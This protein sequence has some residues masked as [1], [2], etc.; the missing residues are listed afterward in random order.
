VENIGMDKAES[1]IISR[2]SVRIMLVDDHPNTAVTLGRA[3][4]RLRE[5]IEVITATSGQEALAFAEQDAIDILITDMM[6]PGMNGFELIEHLHAHPAGR[7]IHTMLMTAYDVP[8]L[9]ETARRLR[10]HDIIIKPV[11]TE[12]I[13]RI[14]AQVL[15]NIGRT[16]SQIQ[17]V[18]N[19]HRFKILIADDAPDNVTL[20]SRYMT[21]EG[22]DYITASNGVEALE[23]ARLEVP[24][25]ILLDVNM[26]EKDG[27]TALRELRAD[28]EIRHIPVIIL[29]A[30]RP[31]PMDIQWGLNLGA[32]DYITKPFDKRE[33][34]ARIRTKLRVKET[35]DVIR[36]R[37]RELSVLPEIGKELSAR[38]DINELTHV[39]LHRTVETLG[40]MMGHIILLDPKGPVHKKYYISEPDPASR[41]VRFPPL[42]DLVDQIKNTRQGLIID[43]TRTDPRWQLIPEN[44]SL[45]MTIV[46]MFGRLDLIGLL[47]L[48][49]EKKGYFKLEH[50]LLLQAIASQA[51]IAVEN[52]QLYE[53]MAQEQSRLSAVLQ[54]AA[55]AIMMFGADGC[56]SLL[57][58]SA[59]T[60]F[61]DYETKLGLPL[62]RN[63]GYDQLIAAL[64]DVLITGKSKTEEILWPD[65]RI[66]SVSFTHVERGGCVVLLHDV[67]HF[68]VLERVKDE[69]IATA[70]HD[71]RNPITAINGFS[72][73][74]PAVGP[75]NEQ[76]QYFAERIHFAAENMKE[77]VENMLDIARIDAGIELQREPLDMNN[78]V[79]EIA[80]EFEPQAKAKQQTLNLNTSECV[81]E[82][83]GD[84]FQLKQALRNLVGNAIKYTPVNGIVDLFTE[85]EHYNV[86]VYVR[87]NGYGI[88]AE[89]LPHIFDRFY[90]VREGALSDIQGN[91]LGLAI[92]KSIIERHGGQI[93]VESEWGKGS[94]LTVTLPLLQQNESQNE[95]IGIFEL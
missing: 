52:A 18:E 80:Q 16:N 47:I 10:I 56:L 79:M 11:P 67:S 20:L 13:C 39:V 95:K 1:K 19:L 46:P 58:P 62:A 76:Q 40:A 26:P 53:R 42:N 45:S 41:E 32:D 5:G 85:T 66:L 33:L 48:T 64:D 12:R 38:L 7:P 14:V 31:S 60:L 24:D 44:P 82:I 87:D 83:D 69:F 86:Q 94:C 68:K 55:D 73:L 37:N 81:A 51:S 49:H 4:S 34:F 74:L 30:A 35:E 8:G 84:P 72:L 23:Q 50:L 28:P 3:I 63:C 61:T 92:V 75:L 71:L 70:S 89:H 27:F 57:N 29:T 88:P 17:K 36:R 43:D 21:S 90:R 2:A 77:L 25:L 9:K 91:G 93:K 54:S 59:G 6:M 78:L 22:Y 65:Q 15:D